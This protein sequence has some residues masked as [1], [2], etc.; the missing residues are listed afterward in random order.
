MRRAGSDVENGAGAYYAILI[1]NLDTS[2][3]LDDVVD[4]IFIVR[5][6]KVRSAG[7]K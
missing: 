2:A 5:G 1:V 7:W 4:L 3:S 6:L